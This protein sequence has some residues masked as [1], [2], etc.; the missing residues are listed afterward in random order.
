MN[1]I[2]IAKELV[3]V[4]KSLAAA[5]D[6]NVAKQRDWLLKNQFKPVASSSKDF[7]K[8]EK[9]VITI[10]AKLENGKV[11]F[12]SWIH[13][14]EGHVEVTA[15]D[16]EDGMQKVLKQSLELCNEND[17]IIKKDF[18]EKYQKARIWIVKAQ[19]QISQLHF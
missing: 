11:N 17:N 6:D 5:E 19:K 10:Y 14:V 4:A 12:E 2:K 8:F 9:G 15:E 13:N 7:F 18:E 3:K 16:I 1:N